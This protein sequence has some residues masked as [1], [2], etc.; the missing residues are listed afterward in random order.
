MSYINHKQNKKEFSTAGYGVQLA[1]W[2]V[3]LAVLTLTGC[4]KFLDVQPQDKIDQPTL[5]NDEQG[6]KD[7]LIGVY[8][9]M[10]KATSAPTTF[11]LYSN[12]LTMGMMSTL[13][14]DYDNA[15]CCQCWC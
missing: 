14:Y 5:F 6:F 1:A 12:N 13:A 15:T 9:G 11:G 2:L 3:V 4:K 7:A 8:L 10:D